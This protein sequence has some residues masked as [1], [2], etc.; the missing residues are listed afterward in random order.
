MTDDRKAYY[1]AR[2]TQSSMTGIIVAMYEL[3]FEYID[4]AKKESS[5]DLENARNAAR[6]I[7][8]LMDALDFK[9]EI[10]INLF[11]LYDFC[12]REISKAM[13]KNDSGYLERPRFIMKELY[14]SFVEVDKQ[15]NSGAAMSNSQKISAGMTYGRTDIT[16][17]MDND[18]NRGFLV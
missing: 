2:F 13:Y 1:K 4:E 8:H 17:V 10:S 11:R 6:V 3:F 7:S 5:V 9:Y 16:E 15:D 18:N 14:G 12:S